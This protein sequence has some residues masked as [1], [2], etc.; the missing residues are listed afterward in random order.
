MI[1]QPP[2]GLSPLNRLLHALAPLSPAD[3][4]DAIGRW[5]ERASIREFDGG[6]KRESAELDA[7][8]EVCAEYGVP[9]RAR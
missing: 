1:D 9:W 6:A 7:A 5:H 4:L 2:P 8:A 3:R